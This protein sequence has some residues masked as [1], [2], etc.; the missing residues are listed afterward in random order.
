MFET[1]QGSLLR[2]KGKSNVNNTK[3]TK[4]VLAAS[5]SGRTYRDEVTE[6]IC[7]A[8][9]DSGLVIVFGA[10]DDLVELRGAIDEELP[11]YNGTRFNLTDNLQVVDS[12]HE[13]DC[14]YCGHAAMIAN[15][16]RIDVHWNDTTPPWTFEAAIPHAQFHIFDDGE[17]FCRGIVLSVDDLIACCRG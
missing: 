4:E 17:E 14:D 13:C 16:V 10:S 3:L 8:A 6:E 15:S 12:S 11:A 7:A 5:L 1:G 2:R 9:K